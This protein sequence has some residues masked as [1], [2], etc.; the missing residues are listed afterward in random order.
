[1]KTKAL[2]LT[3]ELVKRQSVTPEDSGC[4]KVIG[5][6]LQAQGFELIPLDANGVKNL[7]AIRGSEGPCFAFAGHTDVVPPGNIDQWIA[8]PFEPTIRDNRLYGRGTADMKASLAAMVVAV[9]E[10]IS[11]RPENKSKIVFLLTSDEEGVA[12][13]GTIRIVEHLKK[14]TDLKIDY[15]VVG[16]PSSK[17]RLGDTIRIGRR[18]SLNGLV[19]IIGVAG[20]VAYPTDA[21]NPI[22]EGLPALDELANHEWDSGNKYYPP[23]SMQISNLRAGT[24]TENVTPSIMECQFNFRFSTEQT[25][26]SL[27]DVTRQIFDRH[28]LNY[29][30]SWRLSGNPFLTPEGI[31]TKTVKTVILDKLNI[32]TELSTGGGTSD[33]RFIAT[34]GTELIELGPLNG[35]IH[36]VDENIIVT[37]IDELKDLYFSIL[38]RI[39]K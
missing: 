38:E 27:K 30:I 37:E 18:G 39:L 21:R 14:K 16:E 32:E 36:K 19:K 28:N 29:E 34:L 33:G 4:L 17:R 31:L 26:D 3:M 5:A 24:G 6:R 23:T 12:T 10:F 20:H 7:L 15:C 11:L 35:S 22:H 13:D 25:A 9:E 2:E 8:P 1:M